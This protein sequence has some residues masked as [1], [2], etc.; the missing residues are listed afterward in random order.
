MLGLNRWLLCLSLSIWES[1]KISRGLGT[2]AMW[3]FW[4]SESG[5]FQNNEHVKNWQSLGLDITWPL[6]ATCCRDYISW[7]FFDKAYLITRE[8]IAAWLWYY[9]P[10]LQLYHSN[11]V[12]IPSL[13]RIIGIVLCW[14]KLRALQFI[15]TGHI[16]IYEFVKGSGKNNID[17]LKNAFV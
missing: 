12:W 3:F 9:T 16:Q 15:S 10:F 17:I 7:L 11:D 8:G 14:S 1:N 5:M 4:G 13:Y 2:S 6:V